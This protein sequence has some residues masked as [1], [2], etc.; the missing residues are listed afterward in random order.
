MNDTLKK[1]AA[2]AVLVPHT[3]WDREWYLTVEQLRPRLVRLF[4]NLR[5]ILD[6][7]PDY[8]CYWLDGQTSVLED[9]WETIGEQ[10]GWLEEALC[11][12]QILFGPWY[13]LVD[14][15]LVSAESIIRNLFEGRRM[16]QRYGQ[17]NQIGYLPDSF[18]H[19]S[20][21]PAILRGFGIDNAFFFRGIDEETLP[22]LELKWESAQGEAVLVSQ[23]RGG[24]SNAQ[25]VD[26][27]RHLQ[28]DRAQGLVNQLRQLENMS[29][30]SVLLLLNGVDQALP[31]HHLD[32]SI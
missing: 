10:P 13:T 20:Q 15:W 4:E 9:Y 19:V 27:E 29:A 24:Y 22:T 32:R 1:A 18:G 14:E 25:R 5:Q 17:E 2:Q 21:M 26:A 11:R 31:T 28:G 30:A 7:E 12:Q 23:L 3:H 8:Q 6:N 16:M